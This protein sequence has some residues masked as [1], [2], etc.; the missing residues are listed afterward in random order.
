MESLVKE[1]AELKRILTTDKIIHIAIKMLACINREIIYHSIR[2]A[3]ISIKIA[4][5]CTINNRCSKKNLLLLA[6]FHTL[7]FFRED[8]YFNYNP[9]G[10][11]PDFFS[12][13]KDTTSKYVFAG[14][15]LKYMTPIGEDAESI[16]HFTEPFNQKLK[17][18]HYQSTYKGVIYLAAR[19]SEYVY[20][21]PN[22]PMPK[23]I[24]D[25]AP[26]F[27][28]PEYV[29]IFKDINKDDAV[30]KEIWNGTYEDTLSSFI[31]EQSFTEEENLKFQY[32]L[33]YLLDF[34]STYTM[35]HSVNT[36]CYAMSLGKRMQLNARQMSDLLTSAILHD[37]GKMATPAR[38]LEFPGKLS[39]EDMGIMRH[40]V[41]HSKRILNGNV[42]QDILENVYRHHEKLNG[43]GYPQHLNAEQLNLIQRI[44]TVAD[45][46]SALN[47]RRSYKDEFSKDKT[48]S[49]ITSMAEN[50]ELDPSIVKY[51]QT[52]MDQL[53][54][55]LSQL[56]ALLQVDFSLVLSKYNDYIYNDDDVEDLKS[57]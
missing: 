13:D 45:I 9:Y 35:T 53:L 46:I 2:T 30:L 49:I 48:I 50:G 32:L 55:E 26:G 8:L 5:K 44:L 39:P 1:V 3:Y 10:H 41:N 18:E 6:L 51:V 38:I 24:D 40:H 15:Y 52:N 34:K 17:E 47:D 11:N 22:T 36:S 33:I 42:P 29:E 19:I 56:Q 43:N 16:E 31:Y 12:T 28:D 57:I 21:N 25:I 54:A 20:K 4:K 27:L 7:G 23:N 14:Y 37:V